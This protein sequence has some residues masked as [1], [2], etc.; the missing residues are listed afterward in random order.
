MVLADRIALVLEDLAHEV[1][2]HDGLERLGYRWVGWG[3]W[4]TKECVVQVLEHFLFKLLIVDIGSLG[5][6]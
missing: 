6:R 4:F 1:L 5:S 2:V 3:I